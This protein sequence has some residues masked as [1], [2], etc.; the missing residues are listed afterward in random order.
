MCE[1]VSLGHLYRKLDFLQCT[2]TL[3]FHKTQQVREETILQSEISLYSCYDLKTNHSVLI[4]SWRHFQR[5]IRHSTNRHLATC[6]GSL[7]TS[8]LVAQVAVPQSAPFSPTLV[9]I[10]LR[11]S[12]Y[13]VSVRKNHSIRKNQGTHFT[14]QLKHCYCL[15][16]SWGSETM[17]W[18]SKDLN[19]SWQIW[20]QHGT[21]AFSSAA[22]KSP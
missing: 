17:L 6:Q 1:C 15:A 22:A 18:T 2:N 11:M 5:D 12:L 3:P 21:Y 16:A 19:W 8:G 9:C 4:I 14:V 10:L 13:K 20:N 7:M